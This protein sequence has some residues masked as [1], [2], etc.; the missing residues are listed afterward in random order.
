MS[1]NYSGP[2]R[3]RAYGTHLRN[4]D[5]SLVTWIRRMIIYYL[6]IAGAAYGIEMVERRSVPDRRKGLLP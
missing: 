6:L 5:G 2:E 1:T 3:R 4:A